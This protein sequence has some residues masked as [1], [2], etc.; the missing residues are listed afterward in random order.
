MIP[1][2]E[3]SIFDRREDRQIDKKEAVLANRESE[4]EPTIKKYE[5]VDMSYIITMGGI[6][7]KRSSRKME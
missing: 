3:K 5:K 6:N 7:T 2:P 4:M 1:V